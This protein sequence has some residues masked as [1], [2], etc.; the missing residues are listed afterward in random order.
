[1]EGLYQQL[2]CLITFMITGIAIGCLF[3]IFRILRR[4][5]KT[6]DWVIF[7][8]DILFWIIA[9]F[10]MLFSIFTFNHGE[11]RAYIFV[12]ILLGIILYILTISK[13]LIKYSVI[14]IKFYKKILS[15]PIN[16]VEG[17][18][19]RLIIKPIVFLLKKIKGGGDSLYKNLHSSTEKV[20]NNKKNHKKLKE[21]EG[22]LEK[23]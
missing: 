1:M 4:S 6:V 14:I 19:K 11:I 16:F 8:Q 2:F 23:M 3:D 12:G 5:F 9:G 10:I 21:K 20:K 13:F 17:I 18:V 7:L 15:Y 22:I